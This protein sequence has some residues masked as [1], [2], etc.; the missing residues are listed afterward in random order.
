MHYPPT[1]LWHV[2]LQTST[3]VYNLYSGV[4]VCRENICGN[5]ILW[6]LF[7]RIRKKKIANIRR[8]KILVPHG[9]FKKFSNTF[10][11]GNNFLSAFVI[12]VN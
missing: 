2:L 4:N 9:I 8:R 6:E 11:I 5:F 10:R 3:F 1:I 7:L 12:S